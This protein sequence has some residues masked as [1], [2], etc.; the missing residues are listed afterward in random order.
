MKTQIGT[1]LA[2]SEASDSLLL[3]GQLT[4]DL[5]PFSKHV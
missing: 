2:I 4:S 1:N 3:K 5:Q